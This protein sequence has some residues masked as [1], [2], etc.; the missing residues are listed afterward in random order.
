MVLLSGRSWAIN[1]LNSSVDSKNIYYYAGYLSDW[2]QISQEASSFFDLFKSGVTTVAFNKSLE[3]AMSH[4]YLSWAASILSLIP[5]S[6]DKVTLSPYYFSDGMV[7][8]TSAI[9]V[10]DC[11]LPHLHNEGKNISVDLGGV[12][13]CRPN[14]IGGVRIFKDYNHLEM[15]T[16]KSDNK[17][18]DSILSDT[19]EIQIKIAQQSVHERFSATDYIYLKNWLSRRYNQTRYLSNDLAQVQSWAISEIVSPIDVKILWEVYS[20]YNK[21]LN[22]TNNSLSCGGEFSWSYGQWGYKSLNCPMI[23]LGLD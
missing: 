1:S 6:A 23:V 10:N 15:V 3:D 4:P 9:Q 18:F 7:P 19:K 22:R 5:V 8:L 14:N 20:A 21:A 16:G 11:I 12:E 13:K 17:L 2:S